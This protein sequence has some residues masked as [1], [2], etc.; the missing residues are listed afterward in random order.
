MHL[1]LHFMTRMELRLQ[2]KTTVKLKYVKPVKSL[3]AVGTKRALNQLNLL[4]LKLISFSYV[5][6]LSLRSTNNWHKFSL[7]YDQAKPMGISFHHQETRPKILHN[8]CNERLLH[9]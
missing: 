5:L 3:I 8:Y 9:G 4:N 2:T 1:I 6:K 7:T